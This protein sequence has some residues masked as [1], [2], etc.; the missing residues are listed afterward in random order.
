MP[1]IAG[2]RLKWQK[3]DIV[4]NWQSRYLDIKR[5][6][7]VEL[8]A[9]VSHIFKLVDVSKHPS[10]LEWHPGPPVM[11][12]RG[13][14]SS[15]CGG[16]GSVARLYHSPLTRT[17]CELLVLPKFHLLLFIYRISICVFNEE[18]T[19]LS[20]FSHFYRAFLHYARLPSPEGLQPV[21]QSRWWESV[22]T[23]TLESL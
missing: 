2:R 10:Q 6:R 21:S 9:D 7:T 20:F 1:S 5:T 17:D 12:Q 23:E 3:W 16:W 14:H 11:V 19:L 13:G 4:T 18:N 15:R 8:D 22:S